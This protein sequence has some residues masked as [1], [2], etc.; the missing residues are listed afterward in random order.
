MV[1]DGSRDGDSRNSGN[2]RGEGTNVGNS[3]RRSFLKAAGAGATA[4]GL[5][6]C[7]GPSDNGGGGG[8]GGGLPDPIKIGAIG[9][10]DAPA[11]QSILDAA[12]LRAKQF[13]NNGGIGG[14]EVELITKD[15]KADPNTT[16][17][18][19]KELIEG[20]GV[21]ATTG[22]FGSGQLVALLGQIASSQTPFLGTGAATEKATQ[23]IAENYEKNK[24]FFRVGPNNTVFL[25]EGVLLLGEA[26]FQ[27]WGW[28]RIALLAEDFEW[29]STY[30]NE[31]KEN[32]ASRTGAELV[33]TEVVAEGTQDFNPIYD[34]FENKNID[35][36]VVG[37]AH[38]GTNALVQWAKNQRPF[39]FGGIHVPT[40]FPSY[41]AATEGAAISTFSLT[42]A[43]AQSEI[44]DKTVPFANAYQEEYDRLPVYTGYI[45]ADAM[46]VLKAAIERAQTVDSDTLVSELE[47]TQFTGTTGTLNFFGKDSD[48][49]HDA[50]PDFVSDEP[51]IPGVH[52]QW[53]TDENGNGEQVPLFPEE[54]AKG[55]Y[56]SPPWVN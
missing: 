45:T 31:L 51:G 19:Y 28:D 55:E 24:Y 12:K 29:A 39:G 52:F 2:D 15:N 38:T 37:L 25:G 7:T 21:H 50:I 20:E 8:G 4:V 27:E 23:R 11:G 22:I 34:Q 56:Q 46:G 54:F 5:A 40:Q 43:T 10:T 9:P 35:G 16:V 26:R 47:K 14:S 49:P 17:S 33:Q 6:G 41:F 32:L 18:V 53:Q 42:S 1:N 44:T 13:N 36:V 3:R 48:Y 30:V